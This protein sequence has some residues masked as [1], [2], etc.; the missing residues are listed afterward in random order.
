MIR[1]LSRLGGLVALALALTAV[2]LTSGTTAF[3]SSVGP[4]H[5]GPHQWFAGEVNGMIE[6]ATVKV[7][8]PGPSTMGR[9]LP[10][11]TLAITWLP[12]IARNFG[13]TGASGRAIAATVGPPVSAAPTILFTTYND[14]LPFPT[15]TPVPCDGTGLVVFSPVAGGKGAKVATVTVS[16]DNVGASA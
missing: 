9:A 16:Y 1:T 6:N 7:V 14:P 12:V 11:Q 13:Y 5:V 10:G 15:N 2:S 8:C 4:T 3:A